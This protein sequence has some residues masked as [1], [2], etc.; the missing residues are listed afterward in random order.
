MINGTA[1]SSFKGCCN[2]CCDSSFFIAVEMFS[3]AA[4]VCSGLE[5]RTNSGTTVLMVQDTLT[6]DASDNHFGMQV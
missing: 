3:R 1:I 2:V 5:S 6:A 4:T